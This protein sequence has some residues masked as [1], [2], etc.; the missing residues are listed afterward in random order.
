MTTHIVRT[1]CTLDCPDTCSLDVTVTDGVIT[2][3]DAAKT[4]DVNSFT[5]GFICQ[6]VQMSTKRIYSPERIMTPLIRNGKKGSGEFRAVSWDEALDL[7]A[8]QIESAI[9]THGVNSIAPYLYNSSSGIIEATSATNELFA[10]LGCPE[11]EHTI[12]AHTYGIAWQQVFP[13]LASADPQAIPF[14]KLLVV[15]GAN[16]TA[17]NSHLA[18]L[19]NECKANGGTVVVVDPRRTGIA[20]RADVHVSLLPGT[21]AVFAMAITA[22]LERTGKLDADFIS[23]HVYGAEEYLAKCRTWSLELAASECGI[24]VALLQ[25]CI[26]LIA[27]SSP[28][29]LRMGYDVERGANGGSGMLAIFSLWAV[30]GHFGKLGSGI[31]GS[32]SR[33][34]S[35]RVASLLPSIDTNRHKVNMNHVGRW[36]AGADAP[37]VLVVQGA[38]PAVT[39]NDQ[40]LMLA[41]LENEAVFTVVHDQVMT[42]TARYADVIFPATTQFEV[43]DA[44]GSYGSFVLQR[45]NKV[46]EP[47]GESRSND[48][49]GR[50]LAARLNVEI[51]TPR[52]A[53]VDLEQSTVVLNTEVSV[54]FLHTF[55]EGGKAVLHSPL[56]E[57]PLPAPQVGRGSTSEFMRLLTSA[58]SRTTNS[59]FA[60]F[61]APK[62]AV[63][64]HPIDAQLRGLADGDT[65]VVHNELARV[66]L[67][68]SVDTRMRPGVCEIPKGLW[69]RHTAS[70]L[71]SNALIADG[72]N[73]LGGGACF[74]EALVLIEK[75]PSH[76]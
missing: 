18:P 36:L 1:A 60:E 65:V 38:N 73:D 31:V 40:Q 37:S 67:P 62:A 75:D 23:Q 25:Q 26:A 35:A 8:S 7:V 9:E 70:G 64:V 69:M 13:G 29:M 39:A 41:G 72:V 16:S 28:A 14:A 57:L 12:C 52:I 49:V 55:P 42:D 22:E 63:S 21:D 4:G 34:S 43:D 32:T 59:M 58:T 47:V 10:R 6:K 51:T 61:N 20:D 19:I 46:I 66:V 76:G 68:V 71:I 48:W 50:E 45:V 3:I 27:T 17:S 11:I 74:N 15:W 44:A 5:Q 24:D 53:D 2:D 56:S 33:A 30:A 54:Q